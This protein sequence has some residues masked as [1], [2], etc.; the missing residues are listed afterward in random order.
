MLAYNAI[1]HSF[2]CGSLIIS[3]SANSVI[4][5]LLW[6]FNEYMYLYSHLPKTLS[7]DIEWHR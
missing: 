3:K 4:T 7:V 1:V 5:K 2:E 6:A